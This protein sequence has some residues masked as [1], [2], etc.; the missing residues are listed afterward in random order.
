MYETDSFWQEIYDD[1]DDDEMYG[2]AGKSD[3]G[4]YDI[5]GDDEVDDDDVEYVGTRAR[6]QVYVDPFG[7]LF[8]NN[9]MAEVVIETSYDVHGRRGSMR[10]SDFF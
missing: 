3:R 9:D 7:D 10:R 8:E 6:R 4:W 5:W 2:K 1:D